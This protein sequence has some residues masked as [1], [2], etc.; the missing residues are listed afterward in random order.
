[1]QNLGL[2]HGSEFYSV[3]TTF[4][5]PTPLGFLTKSKLNDIQRPRCNMQMSQ[6][7]QT[8]SVSR[9]G[10]ELFCDERRVDWILK[11]LCYDPHSKL[12]GI[13]APP[14]ARLKFADP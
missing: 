9:P 10:R 11:I 13:Q 14:L 12:F 4:G 6:R 1:M 2:L 5:G 3:R 7:L 8:T